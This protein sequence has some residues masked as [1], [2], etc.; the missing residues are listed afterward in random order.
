MLW[1]P[2][3]L[4]VTVLLVY[5]FFRSRKW[6]WVVVPTTLCVL[7]TGIV[8]AID[9]VSQTS[10]IEVWSGYI[11]DW[12]HEE[13]WDEWVPP[14]ESCSTDSNGNKTCTTTPGYWVHHYAENYLKTTDR[15]W[16]SI[17]YTP[18]GTKMNDRFPNKTSELK[19]M[20]PSG[21]PTA[22]R[23]RYVNKVQASYSIYRH[24]EIDLK[25]YPDLPK[26]PDKISDELYVNRIVGNVPNKEIA[27]NILSKTNSYLNHMVP[28]PDNPK[29][30]RSYKQV[31]LIFVNLGVNKPEEYGFALQDYWDG[32]NKNDFVVSFS[33][34]EAGDVSWAYPFSWS[35]SE[36]LKIEVKQLMEKQYKLDN[37]VPI[38]ESVAEL[39]EE[40]FERKEFADFN[41]LQ[42]ELSLIAHLFIWILCLV[43]I[44]ASIFMDQ[45]NIQPTKLV[46]RHRRR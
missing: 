9:F 27:N 44:V 13:E 1:I 6:L 17:H 25:D 18:D 40:K 12:E 8:I 3:V 34:N 26:Y 19:K 4:T 30:N 11:V 46:L 16:F 5:Q 10:D 36:L 32:G 21:T 39:I 2:I 38:V 7:I 41:Y 23:H 22:S 45:K 28:D 31:N 42:I 35:E 29:K 37:F 24:A 43:I 33:M 14:S 20:F 15:G